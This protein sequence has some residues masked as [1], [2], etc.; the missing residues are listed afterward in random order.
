M[1]A[2]RRRILIVSPIPSHP[3]DQGN[4][5]RIFTLGRLLQSAGAEV[6]M[7]GCTSCRSRA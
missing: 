7:L 2:A 5:V 1:S 6:H 3:Q 4:S